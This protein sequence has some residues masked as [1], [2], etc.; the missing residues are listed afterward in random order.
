MIERL[1]HL[2]GK[3][4]GHAGTRVNAMSQLSFASCNA[5]TMSVIYVTNGVEFSVGRGS[6]L[7]RMAGVSDWI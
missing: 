4:I 5:T 6:R 3:I 7:K 2:V 1:R